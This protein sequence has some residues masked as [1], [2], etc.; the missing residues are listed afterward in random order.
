MIEIRKSVRKHLN[1]IN[2]LYTKSSSNLRF[3]DKLTQAQLVQPGKLVQPGTS[4]N[5]PV[6]EVTDD[7]I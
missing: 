4:H 2:K 1:I 6:F 5:G 3:K 7:K